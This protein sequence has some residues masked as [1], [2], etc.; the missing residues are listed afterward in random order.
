M[1]LKDQYIKLTTAS[2]LY[3]CNIPMIG[4]TGGIATGKSAVSQILETFNIPV[5]C[6]DKIIKKI[7]EKKDSF[8]FLQT[9][10]PAIINNEKIDFK[11][12]REDVFSNPAHLEMVENF[13]HPQIEEFFKAQLKPPYNFVV[14][15]VPLLF[16]KNLASLFDITITVYASKETQ[17]NRLVERDK[18]SLELANKII[19]VQMDIEK[20][21][22]LSTFIIFND[23]NDKVELLKKIKEFLPTILENY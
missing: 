20:K 14:Y 21:K 12:L 15:D 19:N 10:F 7:Y 5:I 9:H 22:L 4:L 18:I 1:K 3:N 17:I 23:K 11:K 6:A 13:L 2:R 8:I 16:E